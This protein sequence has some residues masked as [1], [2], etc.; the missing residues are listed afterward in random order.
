VNGLVESDVGGESV[1]VGIE[2]VYGMV[3]VLRTM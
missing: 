3:A 1:V 2:R